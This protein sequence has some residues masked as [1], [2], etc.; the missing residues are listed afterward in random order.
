VQNELVL[1]ES[2]FCKRLTEADVKDCVHSA[3]F[4]A[5]MLDLDWTRLMQ[6][7]KFTALVAREFKLHETGLT[8]SQQYKAVLDKASVPCFASLCSRA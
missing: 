5:R 6:K 1:E 7:D 8:V 4:F 3:R 2:I